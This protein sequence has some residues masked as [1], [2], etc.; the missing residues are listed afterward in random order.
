MEQNTKIAW[1]DSVSNTCLIP[2]VY[3]L[4]CLAWDI[5]INNLW[6]E[7]RNVIIKRQISCLVAGRREATEQK[8]Y[9]KSILNQC[10]K[11]QDDK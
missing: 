9:H 4:P 10:K 11:G 6:T 5:L 8:V 1:K 3:F 2:Y 7:Q